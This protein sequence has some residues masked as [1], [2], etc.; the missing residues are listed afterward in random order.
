MGDIITSFRFEKCFSTS[1]EV[2]SAGSSKSVSI[3]YHELVRNATKL[4]ICVKKQRYFQNLS[5]MVGFVVFQ[6][7]CWAVHGFTGLCC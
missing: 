2:D 3:S 7:G 6:H 4:N 5:G 1:G